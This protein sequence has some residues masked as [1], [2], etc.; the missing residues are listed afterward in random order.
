MEEVQNRQRCAE[1]SA[2]LEREA[3]P[4]P[5]EAPH[6]AAAAE[7]RV[8]QRRQRRPQNG[9]PQDLFISSLIGASVFE[10][11]AILFGR[12]PNSMQYKQMLAKSQEA[13]L[14]ILER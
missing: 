13:L 8:P 12:R 5:Q 9:H 1:A 7:V 4:E 14:H 11:F 3:A 10:L 6:G 2:A